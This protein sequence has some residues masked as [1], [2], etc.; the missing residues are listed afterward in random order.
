MIRCLL[1]IGCLLFGAECVFAQVPVPSVVKQQTTQRPRRWWLTGPMTAPSSQPSAIPEPQES[2]SAV[3]TATPVPAVVS[4]PQPTPTPYQPGHLNLPA[5]LSPQA[6]LKVSKKHQRLQLIEQQ[7]VLVSIPVSTGL[8]A[9]DTP[10]GTFRIL[11]RVAHPSYY[12][13]PHLGRRSWPARHPNNPLG[14]HW[15]Q[16][17][18]G[19]YKTRVAIGLHG[20]DQPQLIGRAVSGG[21]IRMHNEDV[22][23]LFRIL[24]V[25]MRVV[26]SAD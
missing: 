22:A 14:T 3:P 21:C 26:I 12:G 25:G 13:S 19:H 2:P 11:S 15:M 23:L 6:W 9:R 8:G 18:V 4:T 7:Q 5:K 16:L 20:T 10:E 17:N 24:R 1:L